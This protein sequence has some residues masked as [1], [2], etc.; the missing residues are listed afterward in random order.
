MSG[1]GTGAT[2][3]S[4]VGSGLAPPTFTKEGAAKATP[5]PFDAKTETADALSQ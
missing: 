2:A 3:E 1:A 4:A 5:S